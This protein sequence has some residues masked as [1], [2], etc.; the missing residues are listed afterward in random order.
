MWLYFHLFSTQ[1]WWCKSETLRCF[2]P[3]NWHKNSSH[4][5]FTSSDAINV[6]P[7]FWN[8]IWNCLLLQTVSTPISLNPVMLLERPLCNCNCLISAN[9]WKFWGSLVWNNW[10]CKYTFSN[11][12][13]ITSV[14]S[15]TT[16]T[17]CMMLSNACLVCSTGYMCKLLPNYIL[18]QKL[19]WKNFL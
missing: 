4:I 6:S 7:N 11:K 12:K 18:I 17:F 16:R 19:Q 8:Y 1:N 10:S 13:A 14:S 15:I 3:Y 5:S 2:E 9:H